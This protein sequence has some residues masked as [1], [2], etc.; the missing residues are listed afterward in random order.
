MMLL[1]YL[2]SNFLEEGAFAQT[3]GVSPTDLS[4]LIEDRVFPSP[5]YVYE[6]KARSMSFVS[7]FVEDDK[8][9]FHLKGHAAWFGAIGRFGLDTEDRARF[10]FFTRYEG[11]K[12]T[13]LISDLGLQ[14]VEFAPDIMF[15]FDNDHAN[16]TWMH[17]LAGV[18]GV[19]TRDGQPES[20]F[21]KQAGVMFIEKMIA[22]G[23]GALSAAHLQLLNRAVLFLDTVESEFAPHEV[24]RTSRQRC[25]NDVNSSFFGNL[26]A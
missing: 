3:C 12:E 14:L 9:R 21:L 6:S 11:A 2:F 19:C 7:D 13:F 24:T 22:G 18:Y 4:R 17:F 15:Q 25:I 16:S 20:V 8:Y 5:S 1:N 10:Y 26:A 23:P